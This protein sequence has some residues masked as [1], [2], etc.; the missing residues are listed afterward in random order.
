MA[1]ESLNEHETAFIEAFV[2]PERR[3][4]FTREMSVPQRRRRFLDRLNH[5]FLDDLD[6]DWVKQRQDYSGHVL[7]DPSL[8]CYVIADEERYD[9]KTVRVSEAF[10]ILHLASF[11]VVVSFIPGK[12]AY[13][14]DEAAPVMRNAWLVREE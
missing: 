2:R 14:K 5:R 6:P 7:A 4:M 8:S 1:D 12:L 10:D 9:S 13:Y 3:Q 11:G